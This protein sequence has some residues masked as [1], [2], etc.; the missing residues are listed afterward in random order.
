MSA[1][2]AASDGTAS[3]EWSGTS[4]FDMIDAGWL[5]ESPKIAESAKTGSDA[6]ML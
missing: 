1:E 3:G 4:V 2:E 5:F 6:A